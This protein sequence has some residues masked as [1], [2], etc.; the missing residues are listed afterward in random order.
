MA[1]KDGAKTGDLIE[2]A[3]ETLLV[4]GVKFTS[5]P[6]VISQQAQ[7][8]TVLLRTTEGKLWLR[9]VSLD[10]AYEPALIKIIHRRDPE[11]VVK[12]LAE[13]K[14]PVR[15]ISEDGG[16]ALNVFKK[17]EREELRIAA[18]HKYGHFQRASESYIE[19]AIKIG[20][21]DF[22][23]DK[24]IRHLRRLLTPDRNSIANQVSK[25]QI[26]RIQSL[27]PTVEKACEYLQEIGVPATL[28]HDDLTDENIV[29][30]K[31]GKSRII[32]WA[33]CVVAPPFGSLLYP[34]SQFER[35]HS[36]TI[37]RTR[38]MDAYLDAWAGDFDRNALNKAV[39]LSI[40]LVPLIRASTWRRS[41]SANALS[42]VHT[43]RMLNSINRWLAR[44]ES[45][46]G[47]VRHLRNT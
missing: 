34:L 24:T 2:W 38:L 12:I 25:S 5:N 42:T 6:T 1:F 39:E 18:L 4:I 10:F 44:L 9:Q 31:C 43:M 19:G 26:Q 41:L 7:S 30:D 8:K 21:P 16:T 22:S 40:C 28:Q 37:N 29:H 3:Q 46:L 33:D 32:D 35:T 23:V 17:S 20:V 13:C 11:F 36:D 47:T 15:W 27:I 14:S 45:N